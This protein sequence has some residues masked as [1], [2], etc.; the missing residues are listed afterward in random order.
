M[1]WVPHFVGG[2]KGQTEG[3]DRKHAGNAGRPEGL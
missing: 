3:D 2:T 1:R